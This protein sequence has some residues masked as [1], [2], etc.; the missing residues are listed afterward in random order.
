LPSFAGFDA[1]DAVLLI[2]VF[3]WL[4]KAEGLLVAAS[5]IAPL[6]AALF[7]GM[8]RRQLASAEPE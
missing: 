4:G 6:V 5:V 7:L 3:V 1:D 8:L 2:P